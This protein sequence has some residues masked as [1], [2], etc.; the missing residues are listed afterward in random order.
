VD[1]A[2]GSR[3]ADRGNIE[4]VD[5]VVAAVV[6]KTGRRPIVYAGFS[7]GVAMAFRAGVLGREPSAGIVAVGADVPPEL[8]ED[9]R[10][11]FPPALMIRGDKDEWY[12]QEKLDNDVAALRAHGADVKT[13]VV[14]GAHEWTDA[15][16]REAGQFL[17]CFAA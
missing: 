12:T 1:D 6:A 17:L 11:R 16:A 3:A 14:D 9:S 13:V 7:Q 8:A 15:V 2:R 4:Y 5:T 10:V